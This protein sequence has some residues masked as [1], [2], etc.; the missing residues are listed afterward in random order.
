MFLIATTSQPVTVERVQHNAL[1]LHHVAQQIT[2]QL[3]TLATQTP[4]A[5]QTPSIRNTFKPLQPRPPA[6]LDNE[7]QKAVGSKTSRYATS[8]E[9][10]SDT[11]S[12]ASKRSKNQQEPRKTVTAKRSSRVVNSDP[13]CSP[14]N[15]ASSGPPIH[16][17][18]SV[19][20]KSQTALDISIP[21]PATPE[22]PQQE[23]NST[24]V[25]VNILSDELY[26]TT[27]DLQSNNLHPQDVNFTPESLISD[28]DASD[29]DLDD[30]SPSDQEAKMQ[31]SNLTLK[32]PLH[33]HLT[34]TPPPMDPP[35]PCSYLDLILA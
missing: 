3:T 6:T 20:Q 16:H 13:G 28:D 30:L 5:N 25:S 17:D 27:D 32:P 21:P 11:S 12:N 24:P 33:P 35:V 19:I 23:S 34:L 8:D 15:Q 14:D 10:N 26:F 7:P 9:D 18:L 22:H 29:H 1:P 4:K 31:F 2:H